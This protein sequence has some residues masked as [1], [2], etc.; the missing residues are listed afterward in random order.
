MHCDLCFERQAKSSHIS[1][2]GK[3]SIVFRAVFREDDPLRRLQ[4]T[5]ELNSKAPKDIQ[6][7]FG[8]MANENYEISRHVKGK[9]HPCVR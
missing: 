6:R 7:L 9:I 3:I 1:S 4:G 5:I 8:D 2:F